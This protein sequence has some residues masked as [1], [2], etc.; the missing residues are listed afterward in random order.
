M[1]R[2]NLNECR[3]DRKIDFCKSAKLIFKCFLSFQFLMMYNKPVAAELQRLFVQKTEANFLNAI[4]KETGKV[5]LECDDIELDNSDNENKT[6]S[7]DYSDTNSNQQYIDINQSK[8]YLYQI[9]CGMRLGS[10][11]SECGCLEESKK[12]L[13][14]TLKLIQQFDLSREHLLLELNCLQKLLHV[15][16]LFCCY[17]EAT[18]TSTQALHVID[19]LY[20]LEKLSELE[21]NNDGKSSYIP[22]SL[23]ANFY[24]ELSFLHFYRSEYDLSYKWSAKALE[25][26]RHDTPVK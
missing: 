22:E 2:E 16:A 5:I 7:N 24:H 18:T 25:Y 9:D 19:Q 3:L 20:S 17:R 12:V 15:Q 13:S 6:N 26:L 14:T 21:G 10:F 4:K 11:L 1:I 8:S 23:L